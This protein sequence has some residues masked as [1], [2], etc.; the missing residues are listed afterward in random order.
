[1]QK[2]KLF[3][4]EKRRKKNHRQ[5]PYATHSLL[6][7]HDSAAALLKKAHA[8][9]PLFLYRFPYLYLCAPP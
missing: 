4:T 5:F 3:L 1:M 8:A 2:M 6:S 7:L 9:F